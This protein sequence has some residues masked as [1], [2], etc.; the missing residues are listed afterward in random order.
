MSTRSFAV[1]LSV[2]ALA[3]A[4]APAASADQVLTL[5]TVQTVTL[6]GQERPEQRST[7]QLWIG[8]GAVARDDGET[9]VVLKGDHLLLIS[10]SAQTY[11]TVELPVDVMAMVPEE[12]RQQVKQR[13]ELGHLNGDLTPSEE[14]KE[15]GGWSAHRYD[16]GLSNQAGM[17]LNLVLWASEDV[18]VDP[19]PYL[20]LTKALAT[21]QPGGDEWVGK[22][23]AIKGFPVLRETTM[24]ADQIH[25]QSEERLLSV[26]DKEAP[27]GMYGAP[28]GY[29]EQPFNAPPPAAGS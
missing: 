4:L 21:L 23:A 10:H 29:T 8:N 14:T 12:M 18:K 20:K 15:V 6:Q 2:L 25:M 9:R 24:D 1:L 7:A 3:A 27:E 11:S 26:Q 16:L 13:M 19:A 28:E 22:L 17:Q 5:E